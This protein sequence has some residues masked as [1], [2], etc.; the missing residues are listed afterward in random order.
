MNPMERYLA[1]YD[2][3]KRMKLDRVPSF[4]QDV[5]PEFFSQNED[6]I[7]ENYDGPL[8]YSLKF[9]APIALGFDSVF[10]GFP[11]SSGTSA[12]EVEDEKGNK[13]K[14]GG[15][16]QMTHGT[17]SYYKGGLLNNRENFEKLRETFKISDSSK[18]IQETIKYHESLRD[19][20]FPVLMTGGIFD[21]VWMAMGIKQFS[22]NFR[23]RTK[24]YQDIVK[25]FAD[26][27]IANVRGLIDATGSRGKVVNILDDVAYKGRSF[28]PPDRW[29][30]D[31][32]PYYKEVTSMIEDAGMIPQIHTDGD[33]TELIPAF[34]D[35]GFKGLQGWEGG[36]DP[37]YIND[38][39]PDF[40]VIGFGDVGEVL[41]FGTIEEVDEHVRMLM[42][43]LKENR[44]FICGPST[45][46]VKEM[47]L[48]NIRAF[49]KAI[50][51]Y[52][53]YN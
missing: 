49:M 16:G 4:V 44:H 47:P 41:P 51:K 21:R 11:S 13:V 20:I 42:D 18:S 2:D 22:R 17:S 12:V 52:G 43:A 45:V 36:A 48:E 53:E 33:V 27:M 25:L 1:V 10:A 31:F 23:K 5:K 35:A 26:I 34:Q 3:K 29:T 28:I 9:D 7:M 46:I 15:S 32:L 24:L 37:Y 19:K 14:M 50:K 38:N 8:T 30:R 39:Y 40:V 6:G